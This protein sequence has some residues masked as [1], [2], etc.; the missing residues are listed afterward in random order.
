MINSDVANLSYLIQRGVVTYPISFKF[1]FNEN[2]SPQLLIKIG[3][4]IATIN[5]DYTLA[6]DNLSLTLIPT[7]IEAA[8]L[9]GPDDYSWMDRIVGKELLVQRNVPFIQPSDYTVGRI[10]PEQIEYDLDASVMRDQQ[11][12]QDL[13]S[14]TVDV[15]LAESLA[16]AAV[17]TANDAV[18][19]AN[20][21]ID[22]ANNA[23]ETANSAVVT[24]NEAK[25]TAE[26]AS[27]DA[28]DAMADA[29]SAVNKASSADLAASQA[30]EL[31]ATAVT[32]AQNAENTVS[33]YDDRFTTVEASI[34]ANADAIQKTR[35]DYIQADSEI[36]QILNNHAGELTTLHNDVDA[37]GDQVSGIEEKIPGTA[38]ATNPLL[39]KEDIADEF[40]K[41][42]G[43]RL[44][45]SFLFEVTSTT[46]EAN[47]GL[48]FV[49]T[50]TGA[51]PLIG[52][53][54]D[55]NGVLRDVA[56]IPKLQGTTVSYN[57][58]L[59]VN[60]GSTSAPVQRI[61][62]KKI[63][64]GLSTY[65]ITIPSAGG[66]MA[67]I[68]D[69]ETTEQE[70][71]AD[72]NS[73]LSE[74][75]TQVTAQAAAIAEKQDKLTAGENI[76]IVDNVIS[77]TGGGAS[78][79]YLPLTGGELTGELAFVLG[80]GTKQRIVPG[81]NVL[82]FKSNSGTTRARYYDGFL[83]IEQI[84]PLYGSGS[85]IGSSALLFDNVYTRKLNN[86]ADLIIP[87]EGGTLARLEDL[88]GLGGGG[89][90]ATVEYVDTE[91]AAVLDYAGDVD[92]RLSSANRNITQLNT[93]LNTVADW[94]RGPK[95]EDGNR[96]ELETEAQNA[97]SAINELN[98]KIGDINTI[99]DNI[100]GEVI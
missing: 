22:S 96:A 27:Q 84:R 41:K 94:V 36:H 14:F 87:T 28:V 26:Q 89:D 52:A 85:T 56:V 76:T 9:T 63:S 71:R 92:T 75:Q 57:T 31:A 49:Q 95:D 37:I 3:D 79:D 11:L 68:E 61:I 93:N 90:Y 16:H 4:D 8:G 64:Y 65:D 80:N 24:A 17:Q 73:G 20:N 69:I 88:E 78:G 77:A 2:N 60:I 12:A 82:E 42:S 5:V 19:S 34:D 58:V 40:V 98:S 45:G 29:A 86:G 6:D 25:S 70:I 46:P 81:S 47:K 51:Q 21:A 30:L 50:E 83:E 35:S 48:L 91:V 66:T 7:E 67:R 72:M 39:T 23:N 43:D 18:E 74:I 55:S 97:Y 53:K 99:L 32:T 1:H 13:E 100:N 33:R 10:S 59:A 38:S 62:A 15:A 54:T 44:S